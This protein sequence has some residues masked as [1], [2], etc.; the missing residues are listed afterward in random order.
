MWGPQNK[1]IHSKEEL[2]VEVERIISKIVESLRKV[3]GIE[4]VVLGGSRAYGNFSGKS[5]IDIG[6]YYSDSSQLDLEDLSRAAAELDDTHRSNIITKIGEWGPWINGGGWLCIDGIATDFL[7]R[8]LSMV[9]AVIEDCLNKQIIIDY[10]AGHPHGF[11]NTIYA[12]ETYYCKALWDPKNLIVKLKNKINP[13]PLAIKKGIID[14][15]LWEADFSIAIAH[16]G[17]SKNDLVYTSGCLYRAISC[18]IQVTY[19]LNE[20]YIMNEKG[21]L[22]G[23]DKFGIV[24]KD[25]RSRVEHIF[26]SFTMKPENMKGLVDQLSD[27]VKEVEELCTKQK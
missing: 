12:A 21:A 22:A 24:P 13:Y 15:F 16:K 26:Y 27:I 5:D 11:I 3:K 8:D 14:K 10:Q 4:A 7:F 1:L 23:T 2:V 20:T 9:S 19:A 6:I 18:L 17:I 25:F